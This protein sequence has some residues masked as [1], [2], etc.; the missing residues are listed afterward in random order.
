MPDYTLEMSHDGPVIGVDEVGRGPLAGPVFAASVSFLSP[1]DAALACL[2]DD[3]KKLSLKR[4]EKAFLALQQNK[5]LRFALGAASS[6][7]IDR[8]N[9]GRACHLA[10][11]RAVQKLLVR[12]RQYHGHY[13]HEK[14][15]LALVD[16]THKPDLPCAVQ[17][18]TGGDSKSLSIAA[19]SIIAKVMRDRLMRG[20]AQRYPWYAWEKNAGYGTRAHKEGLGHRGVTPHH[21]RSFAPVHTL[22]QK[23]FA[24]SPVAGR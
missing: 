2:I 20:L 24:N 3:S 9:I 18:V 19:A 5:G 17:M 6:A 1:P 15:V 13:S 4:R 14:P 16:G 12:L 23:G 10:M 7:E 22:V 21:R 8:L 11:Y